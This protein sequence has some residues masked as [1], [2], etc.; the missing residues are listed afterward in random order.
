MADTG[1]LAI[2]GFKAGTINYVTLRGYVPNPASS[3]LNAGLV[4]RGFGIANVHR[5]A[6]RGFVPNPATGG[7]GAFWVFGE[8]I[9]R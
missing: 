6:L 8:S 9:V 5:T 7:S 1:H 4:T 3:T 2:R